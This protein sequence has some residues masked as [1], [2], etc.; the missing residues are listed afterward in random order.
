[1]VKNHQ[2]LS[3]STHQGRIQKHYT[4]NRLLF[5]KNSDFHWEKYWIV[6]QMN[7]QVFLSQLFGILM[8]KFSNLYEVVDMAYYGKYF[9]P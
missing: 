8:I 9:I 7:L 4:E 6:R 2:E 3:V 5:L 1:V